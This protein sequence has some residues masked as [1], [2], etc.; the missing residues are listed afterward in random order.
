MESSG[1]GIS[2]VMGKWAGR[3][4]FTVLSVGRVHVNVEFF[5][6][7]QGLLEEDNLL[8]A[9]D[10]TGGRISLAL[11]IALHA[12]QLDHLLDTLEVL[13]LDVELELDLGEHELDSGA[14]VWRVVFDEI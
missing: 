6:S 12:V 9:L 10:A 3:G 14:E 8:L 7:F 1:R 5:V 4:P 13:L 2:T 11:A